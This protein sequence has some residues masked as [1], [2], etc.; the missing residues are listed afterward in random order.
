MWST[1]NGHGLWFPESLQP[2]GH[3]ISIGDVGY[4]MKDGGQFF[5][6][7]NAEHPNLEETAALLSDDERNHLELLAKKPL[8]YPKDLIAWNP[9]AIQENVCSTQTSVNEV[10]FG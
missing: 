9:S 6:F 7:F 10:E 3:T 2:A 1:K 8:K 5:R 4:I